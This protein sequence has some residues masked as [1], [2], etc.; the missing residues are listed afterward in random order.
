MT[1]STH[2]RLDASIRAVCPIDGTSGDLASLRIDYAP[3]ATAQQRADALSVVAAFDGSQAAQDAW[4][5]ALVPERKDLR[6]QAAQA[7]LDLDAFLA[8][9][10]PT[11]AQTLAVVKKLCQ[12]NKRLIVRLIQ[13]D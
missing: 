1:P 11:Q 3:S 12:Q 2:A 7:L 9:A 4:E 6:D 8:L 5:A 10:A 13:V